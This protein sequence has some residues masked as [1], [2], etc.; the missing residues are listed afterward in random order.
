M[1]CCAARTSS[2]TREC[3]RCSGDNPF[4]EVV[5]GDPAVRPSSK[6]DFVGDVSLCFVVTLS[7]DDDALAVAV[8]V[9]VAA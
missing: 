3:R 1:R 6:V 4:G 2:S 7:G 8:A 5:S 9:A